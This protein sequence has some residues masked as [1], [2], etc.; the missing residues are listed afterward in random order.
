MDL[1]SLSPYVRLA[2]DSEVPPTIYLRER[3]IFD[4]ELIY[5]KSGEVKIKIEKNEYHGIPG[6]IFLFKPKQMHS[7]KII[8]NKPLRQPHIHFD[9]IYEPN[10][11]D[12]KVS[13]KP[14]DNMSPEDMAMFRD[15]ITEDIIKPFPNHIRMQNTLAFEKLIFEI[16]R[17]FENR[18]PFYEVAIKALFMQ[19][20]TQLLREIYWMNNAHILSNME[21]LTKVKG[22]LDSNLDIDIPL[23]TIAEYAHMNSYYLTRLFK[24]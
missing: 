12:I 17:E 1:N 8:G 10:S 15:D 13:F 14:I 22:Y 2:W 16:I 24:K 6:D 23:D 11:P 5:I 7:M 4:Y 21:I 9:L 20:W 18:T 3:V 19:L